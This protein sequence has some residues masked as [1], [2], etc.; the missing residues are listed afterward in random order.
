MSLSCCS[1]SFSN[2]PK[3]SWAWTTF[4]HVKDL[5]QVSPNVKLSLQKKT[6]PLLTHFNNLNNRV[7]KYVSCN[8][9]QNTLQSGYKDEMKEGICSSNALSYFFPGYGLKEIDEISLRFNLDRITQHLLFIVS[10]ILTCVLRWKQPMRERGYHEPGKLL[11]KLGSRTPHLWKEQRDMQ[12]TCIKGNNKSTDFF[13]SKKK[14]L[15]FPSQQPIL[16]VRAVKV[17]HRSICGSIQA[18]HVSRFGV[19]ASREKKLVTVPRNSHTKYPFNFQTLLHLILFLREHNLFRK[20]Q[21]N[22]TS[23]STCTK[24]DLRDSQPSEKKSEPQEK[25]YTSSHPR[26]TFHKPETIIP[27]MHRGKARP[28]R[29]DVIDIHQHVLIQVFHLAVLRPAIEDLKEE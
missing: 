25:V 7:R 3:H 5:S 13:R 28:G 17:K 16:T 23:K 9:F 29:P 6:L 10:C 18:L 14:K 2:Y 1:L 12:V 27:E 24:S 11:F 19:Q 4:L 21:K 20:N 26:I 8:K 22:L 15:A